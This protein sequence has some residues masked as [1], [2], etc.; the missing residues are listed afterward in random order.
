MLDFGHRPCAI[1]V[2]CWT[3]VTALHHLG[4][5]H[6]SCCA[7]WS[8]NSGCT[9]TVALLDQMIGGNREWVESDKFSSLLNSLFWYSCA[10][11]R[12]GSWVRSVDRR[13]SPY[14]HTYSSTTSR[15]IEPKR[16]FLCFTILPLEKIIMIYQMLLNLRT[17]MYVCMYVWT[18]PSI[19]GFHSRT[20]PKIS[21]GLPKQSM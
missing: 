5:R 2:H 14:I 16:K 13:L 4:T 3:S 1:F 7:L 10:D 20:N 15:G 19:D 18:E 12:I 8:S 9:L 21:T 11:F 17:R 6:S